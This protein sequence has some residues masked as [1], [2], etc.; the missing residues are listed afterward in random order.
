MRPG[1]DLPPCDDRLI[2]DVWMSYYHF[3]TL[4]M[5]DDLGLFTR[6]AERP[7]TPEEVS[8][9]L[10][11]SPRA[12][13]ALLGVLAS[14]GFI[15]RQDGRFHLAEVARHYLLPTS[16]YYWGGMLHFVRD[17]PIT[18]ASLQEALVKDKPRVYDGRDMFDVH[19][20][21][22]ALAKAF[23][24]AMHVRH[25]HVGVACAARGDFS[26]VRRLLDVGG[27]S[28]CYSIALALRH[29]A[30]R[31]TVMELAGVA[32]LA[33]GY[34]A[35]YGVRERVDAKVVNMFR[36]P[37]PAGYDAV[38]FGNIYHDWDREKCALLTR[39][40]FEALPSGG[41]I[42]V[43]EILLNETKDGPLPAA[44]DSMHMVFFTE[45]KQ[46]SPGEFESLFREAGF[47]DFSVTPTYG[48]YSLVSARKP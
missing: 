10:R 35:Q 23:T 11:L 36:E 5:A 2:W 41:R 8:Q 28:G 37:W 29:P 3:P 6:L 43:H 4:C 22:P 20:M 33:E 39:K 19:E 17:L 26:G 48:Y 21:E 24:H 16:P 34:A 40:S 13:E 7:S 38:F 15:A 1:L 31:C 14:L 47:R 46:Q 27:G 9:A 45:G 32:K 42:Y 25:F 18:R 12:A 30:M 44:T